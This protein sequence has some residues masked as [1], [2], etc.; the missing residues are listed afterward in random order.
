[1]DELRHLSPQEIEDG[2]KQVLT[3]VDAVGEDMVDHLGMYEGLRLL[4][5][6][7][8]DELAVRGYGEEQAAMIGRGAMMA[9]MSLIECVEIKALRQEVVEPNIEGDQL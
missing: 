8:E 7:L 5:H 4:P 1:M 2:V 6:I 3:T 9:V